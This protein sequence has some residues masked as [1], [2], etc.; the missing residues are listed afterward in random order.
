MELVDDFVWENYE[1][2]SRDDNCYTKLKNWIG[3]AVKEC[4]KSKLCSFALEREQEQLFVLDK[5]YSMRRSHE[6]CDAF[7]KFIA[8]RNQLYHV[9]MIIGVW[10]RS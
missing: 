6:D 7:D 9:Y 8:Q 10:L 3:T 2:W 5:L 4:P 1:S